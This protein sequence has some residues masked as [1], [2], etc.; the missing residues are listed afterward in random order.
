MT[1]PEDITRVLTQASKPLAVA[2]IA[3]KTGGDVR[4]C[5]AILWQ[6]P[7]HFVWQPGHK[8]TVANPKSVSPREEIVDAP[9][10]RTRMISAN[11]P[12]ELRAITLSSGLKVSVNRRPLDSDSFFSVRS[13]GSTITL[14]L[15]ST[16]EVFA[17]LPMPFETDQNETGF[18]ELCELLLTAW[19]LYEDGIPGG[20]TKRAMEDARFLWGRRTIEMLR[21]S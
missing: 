12:R 18:K 14:T 5:D 9:D 6:N 17:N 16:H 2:E 20:S 10:A 7:R 8:W 15:N 3:E 13:A 4:E 1:T 19:A 21:E 11:L